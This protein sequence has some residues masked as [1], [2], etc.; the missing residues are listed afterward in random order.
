MAEKYIYNGPVI[1]FNTCI[2]SRW[3]AE[4]YAV[5]PTKARSNLV[6]RYKK[7]NGFANTAKITLPGELKLARGGR[8]G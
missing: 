5:S 6:Y 8:Y 2:Q 1:K 7:E 4:T 3:S